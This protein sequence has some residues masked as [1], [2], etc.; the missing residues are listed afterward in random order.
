[1]SEEFDKWF[2]G[3]QECHGDLKREYRKAWDAA[4]RTGHTP[5][6]MAIGAV[7]C[8]LTVSF[9]NMNGRDKLKNAVELLKYE[10][11]LLNK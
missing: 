7:L 4:L 5:I 3:N 1:M 10:I 11:K 2:N 9:F 6:L 8:E